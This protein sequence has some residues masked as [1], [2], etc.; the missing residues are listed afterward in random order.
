MFAPPDRVPRAASS[1]LLELR[2]LRSQLAAVTRA[3]VVR[4]WAIRSASL[5]LAIGIGAVAAVAASRVLF[6]RAPIGGTS[7]LFALY[8]ATA[9]VGI[10]LAILAQLVAVAK[11]LGD[12]V[13]PPSSKVISMAA[14]LRGHLKPPSELTSRPINAA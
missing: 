11:R 14:R 9:A 6:A 8:G 10:G 13:T 7:G 1:R 12:S 2:W 3:H 5:A 4:L